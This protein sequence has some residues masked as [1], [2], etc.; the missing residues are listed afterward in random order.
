MMGSNS[1]YAGNDQKTPVKKQKAPAKKKKAPAKQQKDE[2]IRVQPPADEEPSHEVQITR[3]FEMGKYEV[4]QAQWYVVMDANP[5][6]FNGPDLPVETVSWNDAQEFIGKLN[7]MNDGYRYRLPTEAEWEYA[8]RAG[9]TG[10]WA[11]DLDS[12]AWYRANSGVQ[13]HPVGQKQPNAWGLHDMLGNV[14]EW[15]QDWY[16]ENHDQNS[17]MSNPTGPSSGVFHVLRGGDFGL[18]ATD[19]PFALRFGYLPEIRYPSAG[20]RLVR[21]VAVP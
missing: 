17:P 12:M 6:H 9:T 13:T 10:A 1:G 11:G 20:F 19:A 14:W 21:E 8:A 16:G 3:G 4:T 5:S 7:A 2:T 18:F 15:C